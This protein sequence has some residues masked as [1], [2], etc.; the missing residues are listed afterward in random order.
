MIKR[1]IYGMGTGTSALV[2]PTSSIR[3]SYHVQDGIIVRFLAHLSNDLD[4]P[5]DALTI[6]HKESPGQ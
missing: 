4:I 2:S 1:N 6:H 5:N 3:F